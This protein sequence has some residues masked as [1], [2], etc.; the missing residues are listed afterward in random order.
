VALSGRLVGP[1]HTEAAMLIPPPLV[2][3]TTWPALGPRLVNR[4]RQNHRHARRTG[5][6]ICPSPMGFL[7]R[8]AQRFII[9]SI[10]RRFGCVR[11]NP[12]HRSDRL[13]EAPLVSRGQYSV[14][15]V[16]G[17]FFTNCTTGWP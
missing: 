7:D 12:R 11:Y 9:Y 1:R 2:Q 17:N 16:L 4:I 14:L 6:T 15:K 10:V 13:L 5:V 8:L 3:N